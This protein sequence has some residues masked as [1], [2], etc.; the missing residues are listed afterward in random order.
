MKTTVFISMAMAMSACS[1][2][3]R[4]GNSGRA[5][6]G[7]Q[8]AVRSAVS[9]EKKAMDSAGKAKASLRVASAKASE[10]L[11]VAS[12]AEKPL[13]TQL[14][15][16]LGDA[17]AQL[18]STVAELQTASGALADSSARVEAVQTEMDGVE[19]E[20]ASAQESERRMA[21]AERF[22]RAASMKLGLLS[23]ALGLWMLRRPLAMAFGVPLL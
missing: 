3:P 18:D 14:Q 23:G 21:A 19:S 9:Y 2:V 20:L 10:L 8:A 13:E 4:T 5:T 15:T 16:A 22:W 6:A 17:G 1:G 7:A 11:V 12:A